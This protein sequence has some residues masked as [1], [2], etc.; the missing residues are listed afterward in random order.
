VKDFHL[1]SLADATYD[2]T[3]AEIEALV[4][5]GLY[6]AFDGKCELT[7]ELLVELSRRTMPLSKTMAESMTMLRAWA[8]NRCRSASTVQQPAMM[9]VNPKGGRKLS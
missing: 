6:A 4:S 1:Q 9:A 7:T 8:E 5:E 3:G 2:W